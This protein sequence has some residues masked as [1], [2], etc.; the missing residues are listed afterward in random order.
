MSLYQSV[1]FSKAPLTNADKA[2]RSVSFGSEQPDR[3]HTVQREVGDL[4][5][6]V[7]RAVLALESR[8]ALPQLYVAS[9]S[10]GE[11][12]GGTDSLVLYG[13]NLLAGRAKASGTIA[14]ITLT[15]L[16]PG[17]PGNDISLAIAVGAGALAVAVAVV[18]NAITVTLADGGSTVADIVTAINA[19]ATASTLVDAAVGT[20]GLLTTAT[21]ATKLSGGT[22]E[23]F[24]VTALSVAGGAL[25]ST[26]LTI[27]ET[28]TN[29]KVVITDDQLGDLVDGDRV[30][31]VIDSHTVRTQALEFIVVA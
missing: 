31:I 10:I 3:P 5:S 12:A 26:A 23:G 19:H 18:G 4:R 21:A 16:R 24:V 8:D 22:G 28:V 13:A 7:E 2:A 1:P 30:S 6:D 17:T 14:G 15:A 9:G 29:A 25:V 20:A 27:S 11:G